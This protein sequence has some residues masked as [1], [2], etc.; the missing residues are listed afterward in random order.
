MKV[1][2]NVFNA[3]NIAQTGSNDASYDVPNKM[4]SY[5][6]KIKNQA[7]FFAALAIAKVF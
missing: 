1:I 5:L 7:V 3:P 4:C 2:K 6:K